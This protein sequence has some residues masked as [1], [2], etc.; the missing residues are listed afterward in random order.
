MS[1]LCLP[2][3]DRKHSTARGEDVKC[4]KDHA[5]QLCPK[6]TTFFP[7][8]EP[9]DKVTWG[10]KH[11]EL[12]HLVCPMTWLSKFDEDPRSASSRIPTLCPNPAFNFYQ[13]LADGKQR[14]HVHDW[15]LL[16]FNEELL[17]M[18]DLFTTFLH[19]E[20]LVR[21]HVPDMTVDLCLCC[22]L[23][24]SQGTWCHQWATLW[25]IQEVRQVTVPGIAYICTLVDIIYPPWVSATHTTQVYF[26]L[27][28]Q[29]AFSAGNGD[30]KFDFFEFYRGLVAFV[31]NGMP[32]E[33]R[34]DLLV[35]WNKQVFPNY[36]AP[37]E[38]D[39][40][41]PTIHGLMKAQIRAQATLQESTNDG[42]N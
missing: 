27:G 2:Q 33:D 39:C 18:D 21:V 28:S 26:A 10:F 7:A 29:E 32:E 5:Q 34:Q 14:A 15:P 23:T 31:E 41:L 30:H 25:E 24:I 20:M 8:L 11:P 13:S 4:I 16:L 19:N 38:K 22:D 9:D 36:V 35:W 12:A 6:S 42:P 3:F 37:E 17:D 40:A 1:V